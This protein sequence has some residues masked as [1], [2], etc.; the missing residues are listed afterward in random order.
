L[1]KLSQLKQKAYQ[2]GKNR[3]WD[4][5]I[6]VYEK[7]LEL[8]K[9]NPTVINELG[10]LCLKAGATAR[11]VKHFLSAASKYRKTGLLN[12]SVA[13]YKKILRHD[14]AN[15]HAH[16]YLA[17]TRASQGLT[18]EGEDH[19]TKFLASSDKLSA[20]LKEIYFKRCVQ[21]FELYPGSP[22]I[23]EALVQIFRMW[24][25]PLEEGRALCLLACT[26]YDAG[27]EATGAKLVA[28][29][30][31]KSPELANY[32]EYNQWLKRVDPA[33]CKPDT[34]ADYNSVSLEDASSDSAAVE[35][36][37]GGGAPDLTD[38][39][40][41]P[42]KEDGGD[43]P[44]LAAGVAAPIVEVEKDDEGC[45]SIDTDDGGD[46][47]G[48]IAE[49]AGATDD[50]A[51]AEEVFSEPQAVASVGDPAAGPAEEKIDLLAQILA[52]DGPGVQNHDSDQL[53]TIT[54]EIG[55]VVGGQAGDDDAG[56]LYEMGLVYLEMGMFDQAC[57]SFEIA[58]ADDDY[59]VR[60]HEMWG[61]TL[62]RANRPDEAVAVLTSG[63]DFADKD[64]RE[65]LG[66]RYHIARAHE[67]AGRPDEA[68]TLY[69]T[70]H[71][72]APG[73]LDVGKRLGQPAGV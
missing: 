1:S 58:A 7:I 3:N 46:L 53:A 42:P 22:P 29:T 73:F 30:L 68:A 72:V 25:K 69:Q 51:A 38:A 66:L 13:I 31:S 33:A 35:A 67:M 20:D 21:L 45:I 62:Q 10:D 56:R 47:E 14:D 59:T 65:S 61:I 27:D 5:A 37:A 60:A 26:R 4:E 23:L 54:S 55:M 18:V 40:P 12:N 2:A 9:N 11:A 71:Q 50:S 44:P 63:L 19:A 36:P 57:E 52:E 41:F 6:T 8:E 24:G 43:N 70:I 17:E 64:S 28:E 34:V 49:A 16:W 39:R 15:L 32:H 48:L